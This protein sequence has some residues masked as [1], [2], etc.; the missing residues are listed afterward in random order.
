MRFPSLF[1]KN[2]IGR[3][4]VIYILL[5][6][7]VVTLALT[8]I[9]LYRDYSYDISQI[10]SRF[11][12]IEATNK[13]VLEE[14]YWLLNYNSI[15]LLLEGLL[16]DEDI[17]YLEITDN[18]GNLAIIKGVV[19]QGDFKQREL[20]L[21]FKGGDTVYPLGK[22]RIVAS[23][24]FV[25]KRLINT[26]LIILLTQAIKTFLVSLFIIALVWNLITR[27]LD[28]ISKY[29]TDLGIEKPPE[30]FSLE[31]R[32]GYW[33]RDDELSRVIASLNTMHKELHR[34]YRDIEH[35]SFHDHLTGLPNRRLL[36]NRLKHEILQCERS[37]QFGALLYVDLDRFKVLNDSL[38][39]SFGD[40]LLEQIASRFKSVVRRVDTVARIGGDEFVFLLSLLSTNRSQA[41]NDAQ[42]VAK[43][44]QA[45]LKSAFSL[46][47][48]DYHISA[49]IGIEIFQGGLVDSETILKRADNA[50]YQAK[51]D[52]RD[53]VRMYQSKMQKE[54]DHLLSTERNLLA[55]INNREFVLYYQP[56]YDLVRKIVSVEVLVRWIMPNGEMVSPAKFIP[57]AEESGLIVSIGA[58]ILRLAF[59][60]AAAEISTL[61][62]AGLQNIAINISPRQ[63]SDPDFTSIITSEI[64]LAGLDPELFLFE[65][66]EEAM[67]SDIDKTIENMNIL[68]RQGFQLSIDDFG[69]GY[70]SLRRLQEFP[71]DELKIDQSF[72]QQIDVNRDDEA[73][74]S[75]IISMAQHLELNVVAEGVEKE[76]QLQ[77]LIQHGCEIFQ[78]YLFSR[79][80]DFQS[81]VQLLEEQIK[82]Q[83]RA[84]K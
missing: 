17:V 75:L 36:E 84:V 12:Q 60:D 35:Q 66:T 74:V 4:L 9:Q 80:I 54:A 49:S 21:E 39:H 26:A 27:H 15:N 77:L 69:T 43:K 16:R 46:Q 2:K 19:P 50:M 47:D 82:S 5:F 68:K 65:L 6:S 55:A 42:K 53:T 78:G 59:R 30:E 28:A 33:T 22:F 67:V 41:I 24:E 81:F 23:L 45:Q 64:E 73:I 20:I 25:Y 7:S 37:G 56:K 3:R 70:S 57:I 61:K 18:M 31:R 79:P 62:R 34:T 52:G 51:S 11:N 29:A 48:Q 44:I 10:E 13:E 58:E 76:A 40:L 71:L 32:E 83:I 1:I 63:F 72:V 38:G 8:V 14:N